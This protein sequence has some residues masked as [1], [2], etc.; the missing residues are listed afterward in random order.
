MFNLSNLMHHT[1]ALQRSLGPIFL[2]IFFFCVVCFLVFVSLCCF[3][4]FARDVNAYY[5]F[6]CIATISL[7]AIVIVP[8]CNY[9]YML[10]VL[11]FSH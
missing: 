1:I 6:L 8:L 5:C 4:F 2:I 3:L 9:C 11:A 10:Q 7:H